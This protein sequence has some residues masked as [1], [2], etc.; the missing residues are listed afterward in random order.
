MECT[1]AP[2]DAAPMRA[3]EPTTDDPGATAGHSLQSELDQGWPRHCKTRDGTEYRIRPIDAD[4]A[5]QDR[6]FIKGLSDSSRYNRMM[7][8][9]REPSA[10]LLDHLVHVDYRHDMALIAVVGA[11]DKETLIGVAR[12]GGDPDRCEFAIAVSD[13]WQLR[14]VGSTLARL[15]FTYAKTHGVR[16]LY[17][18][19]FA[20][21]VRM[22]KLAESMQ[23]TVRRSCNDDAVVEIWRTL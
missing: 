10:E 8:L 23:M 18:I 5:E 6:A 2:D 16:R 3:A 17:G 14:G 20:N 21:N 13:E 11:K 9:A 22:L 12:Y 15:L 19:V 7:G 4:D 1:T